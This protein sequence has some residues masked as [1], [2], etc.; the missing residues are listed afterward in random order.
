MTCCVDTAPRA[1]GNAGFGFQAACFVCN[2]IH[3]TL[4]SGVSTLPLTVPIQGANGELVGMSTSPF[5]ILGS[6]NISVSSEARSSIY[7]AG[8]PATEVNEHQTNH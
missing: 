2:A 5:F 1:T 3:G 8:L 6:D 7:Q 4:H